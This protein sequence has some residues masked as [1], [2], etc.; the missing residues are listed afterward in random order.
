MP[1]DILGMGI[2]SSA[3]QMV[4]SSGLLHILP[5]KTAIKH[6][7]TLFLRGWEGIFGLKSAA[8]SVFRL[9]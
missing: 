9:N 3:R 2:F 6:L 5:S 4:F 7:I 1:R 8:N